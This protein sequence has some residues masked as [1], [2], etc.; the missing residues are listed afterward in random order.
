[1]FSVNQLVKHTCVCLYLFTQET[2]THIRN[3]NAAEVLSGAKLQFL[4]TNKLLETLRSLHCFVC[5]FY[6]SCSAL[7]SPPQVSL[8]PACI[9]RIISFVELL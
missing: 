2:H 3:N 5:L 8:G 1:M 7:K 4:L 6:D 9:R